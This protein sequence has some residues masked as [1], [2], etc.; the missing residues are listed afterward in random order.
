LLTV[1]KHLMVQQLPVKS[2]FKMTTFRRGDLAFSKNTQDGLKILA[3]MASILLVVNQIKL[4]LGN[5]KAS[6]KKSGT[7]QLKINLIQI[8]N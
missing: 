6:Q 8:T 1:F 4:L 2:T 3:I 5:A 7:E